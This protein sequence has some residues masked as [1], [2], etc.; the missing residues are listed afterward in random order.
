MKTLE[1]GGGAEPERAGRYS[2]CDADATIDGTNFQ[3]SPTR[4]LMGHSPPEFFEMK[5]AWADGRAS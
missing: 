3:F 4:E 1:G 5:K 2:R